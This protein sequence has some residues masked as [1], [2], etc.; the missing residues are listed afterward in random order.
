[1][2]YLVSY[3]LISF[4]ALTSCGLLGGDDR[5]DIP[6]KIVFAADDE[7]NTPQIY[8]MNA[9]G[10]GVRQLTDFPPEGGAAD[11]AWSL[12]GSRIVFA[13][14]TGATTLGP[15]L[16]L[17]DADGGNMRPLKRMQRES[18]KA[19]IGSAP[20]WS[21]DGTKIA[22][23]VCTNCEQGGDNYEISTVE[24]AG[25]D[26]DPDQIHAVTD[27]PASDTY[28]AW[29]PDG[30]RIAFTSNRDYVNADS[31]RFRQDLYLI[32]TDGSN[33][34][35][36]TNTGFA[37]DPIWNP[38]SS[39]ITFR[40]S[41]PNTDMG[42][43]QVDL[44]TQQISRIENYLSG[45]NQLFPQAWSADGDL[46]LATGRVL[47]A[48]QEFFIYI[49]DTTNNQTQQLSLDPTEISGVDWWIPDEN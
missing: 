37:K 14:Y 30:S 15:Y 39:A 24:V 45:N 26:Y 20:D 43:F 21:P 18:P 4:L 31:M 27:H 41:D 13:N 6:G 40:S 19:L 8:T 38:S 5:P 35:R 42:L 44:Q 2:K 11:P 25:E 1:M 7:A 48:P 49:I 17:M 12:D 47:S 23:Q 32:S 29:S 33:L 3:I 16:Y 46:L 9:D 36:I 22:Y 28:P 34:K 10:S